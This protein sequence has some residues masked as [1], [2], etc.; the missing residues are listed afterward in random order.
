MLARHPRERGVDFRQAVRS[1]ATRGLIELN[2]EIEA[3]SVVDVI[4]IEH[5][6]QHRRI[7]KTLHSSL[8][9]L[10]ESR[11]LRICCSISSV[12]DAASGSSE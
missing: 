4:A 1:T 8:P 7:E 5:R 11:S 2:E 12:A 6:H 9:R 3:R 10:V